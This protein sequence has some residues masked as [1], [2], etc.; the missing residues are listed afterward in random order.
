MQCNRTDDE[1]RRYL[2]FLPLV[3]SFF[4]AALCLFA[5]SAFPV[6]VTVYRLFA[7]DKLLSQIPAAP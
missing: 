4:S 5:A 1:H 3:I 6:F 7:V 2:I